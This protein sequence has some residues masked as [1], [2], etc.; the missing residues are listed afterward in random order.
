MDTKRARIDPRTAEGTLFRAITY[1]M[2]AHG[3]KPACFPT[4]EK[5][6]L[7]CE[8]A[9]L[10]PP[11]VETGWCEDCNAEYQAK[12]GRLGKCKRP[13]I[14]FDEHGGFTDNAHRDYWFRIAKNIKNGTGVMPEV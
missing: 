11:S 12:M 5:F 2:E 7:W 1:H 6:I 14:R 4:V 13:D 8:P 10:A 9:R 3:Q